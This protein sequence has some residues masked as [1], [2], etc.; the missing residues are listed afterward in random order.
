MKYEKNCIGFSKLLRYDD[1]TGVWYMGV[2][3]MMVLQYYSTTVLQY[4]QYHTIITCRLIIWPPPGTILI[5]CGLL[6]GLTGPGAY[7][8]AWKLYISPFSNP[9]QATRLAEKKKLADFVTYIP[10]TCVWPTSRVG[11]P[12]PKVSFFHRRKILLRTMLLIR[13]LIF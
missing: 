9:F 1:I 5:F 13:F 8:Y 12:T 7:A 11:L 6:T 10:C 2:W 3:Y 4:L